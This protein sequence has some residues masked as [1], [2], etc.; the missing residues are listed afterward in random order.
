MVGIWAVSV[1]FFQLF[2]IFEIFIIKFL[3]FRAMEDCLGRIILEAGS[4]GRQLS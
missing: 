2:C 1:K 3:E 4:Q